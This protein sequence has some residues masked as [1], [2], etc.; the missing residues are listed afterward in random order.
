M[1]KSELKSLLKIIVEEVVASKKG[2]L[3]E[4]KGLSGF[5]K[6]QAT[7]DHTEKVASSTDLTG[8]T[9]PVEKEESK[10]LPVVKKPSAPQKVG[11]IK[12]EIIQ[13]I[14]E[15]I[16]E[17]ARTAG[18]IG[19]KYKVEDPTSPTGWSIKG[20]KKIPDGTPTEAPSKL[21][22]KSIAPTSK[23]LDSADDTEDADD[24]EVGPETS[25]EEVNTKVKVIIDGDE[26]GT[27]D[28]AKIKGSAAG[29]LS[30]IL[31]ANDVLFKLDQEVVEKLEELNDLFVAEKLPVGTTLNLTFGENSIKLMK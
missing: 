18:A 9:E 6:S 11:S 12:E 15:E 31:R 27:M 22:K 24:E 2:K 25:T 23:S 19:S 30:S 1:K 4:A 8:N 26:I 29:Y 21:G 16:E 14:R 28:F 7:K 10:K 13:M 5:K 17:M 20:H 3:H